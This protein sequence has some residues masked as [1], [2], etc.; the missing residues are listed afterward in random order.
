MPGKILLNDIRKWRDVIK[1]PDTRH[2]DWE[3][4]T[5]RKPIL[6]IALI[7]RYPVSVEIIS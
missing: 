2:R 4:I 1:N 5:K 7:W 3:D 6:S